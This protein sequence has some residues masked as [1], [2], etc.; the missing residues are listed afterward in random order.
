MADDVT[1][2]VHVR[3]LTGP[4]FRS[5]TH[6]INQLQR[7]ANGTLGTLRTLGGQLDGVASSAA[8]AGQS[9]GG[10]MG[11][12]GQ[13]IGAA[14]ALG[15]TLLPTIGALAPMLT[16]LAVVGG[17]A[18]LAM[19][20]LKK[21]AKQLKGPFEE[22]QKIANKA[23]APHTEKAVKSLK[24]AM[25]DLN[26][27]IKLGADTFGRITEKAARFADSPA[28]KGAL[29]KNAEM[30]AKWVEEFA[31][32]VGTFTQAFLDFGTKSQP[33][34]DAWDQLL[35]GTLDTGL[36]DM[37]KEMEVGIGGSSDVLSGLASLINDSLLPTLGQVAGRFADAFGPLL[38]EMLIGAGHAVELFGELF[39]GAM[40]L[41]EP[42]ADVAA[43]LFRGLNEIFKIGAS[44]AGDFTKAFGGA[45]LDTVAE[46][47]G[48]GGKV[49]SMRGGFTRFSDWVK[50][51]QATI[52][53]AFLAMGSA[54]VDMVNLGIQSVPLLIGAF[55]GMADMVLTV[56]DGMISGLAG[57]FGDVPIVGEFFKDANEQFDELAGGFRETL[58][59]MQE[60]SEE[61]A[62]IAGEKL[63]RI[64][65]KVGVD[66]AEASLE[67]I[68][69]QLK[70]PNLTAT[71]KAKLEVEK[72]EAEER[73]REA[74]ERL[75][76][77]DG[78]K[79]NANV[80]ANLSGFLGG[81]AVAN[82]IA[83]R[84]KSVKV[85]ANL[86]PFRSAV[87]GLAGQV[88]GTSYIN[89]AYRQ[90][91][92]AI[93]GGALSLMRANGGPVQRRADGGALQHFP[94]GG[95]VQGPGGPRTD[96]IFATFAS[97]A[98][99]AVSDTEF[100]VQSSAV[101]K[102]GLPMLEALNA[103]TLK[104]AR[105]AKGGVTKGEAAARKAAMSDLTISRFG[106]AAGYRRS[107]FGSALANASSISSLVD[108]LNQWRTII[109]KATHGS[110]E[111]RLLKQLDSTGKK[112]LNYERQLDKASSSLQK[113]RDRLNELKDAALQLR[114]SVKS[115]V[116][117]SANITR[118]QG[119]GPITVA[120]IM[121][122][123]TQSRDKADAFAKALAD[124]RKK[125]LSAA[126]IQQ[127]GE[128]GIEG[129]GL[130]TAG[131]LLGASSSEITSM[132]QLQSQ[133]TSAAVAAGKTTA[134]AVYAGQI[135]TQE[136]LVKAWEKTTKALQGSMDSLAKA[137]ERAVEKAFGKKAAGGIVGAAASGGIRSNLT[138][139][140]EQGPELLNLPP[141][142]RVWSNPDS[143]RMQRQAWAS[144]LNEPPRGTRAGMP[145]GG[146]QEVRVVLDVRTGDQNQWAQYL[147]ETLR[148]EVRARGG[149]QP[150]FQPPRSR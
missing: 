137:M 69:E 19:D 103:G 65:V 44:V 10:G 39:S 112:L 116:L 109:R 97:G 35:G 6:N 23:V 41:V 93:G 29:A 18:A 40:T 118:N 55:R 22:W 91:G 72:K 114:D 130:E 4:G 42:A 77:F 26:P 73:L 46:F 84:G 121:G 13:A 9:F 1:I 133:I 124:L 58:G 143:K 56:I 48:A 78:K 144:M 92:S 126:L 139:V 94:N 8:N 66:Q 67:Y 99:A 104:M 47:A 82:K 125:G 140:G 127:I 89:V 57:A 49:D 110:T 36:P 21:K 129:G 150:T 102:Y 64:Q 147:V 2:T 50:E 24:S 76:A 138:W 120:S 149:M 74:R 132:N 98:T 38:K 148:K 80:G 27:V 108:A 62:D 52:R 63:N 100:V 136:K 16:G 128:A 68:K 111:N 145:A 71:R 15:T 7:N 95:L 85:G 115:G 25:K 141:G 11:L 142:A 135:A 12:R 113:S 17:G 70:D 20:D 119:G 88:V 3:D 34:L 107:E 30:G 43:D 14:A 83:P 106:Q 101:K 54:M 45:L 33:A 117:S 60:K 28:F 51:N 81:I 86:G 37:F 31:G 87:G 105:L 61:F 90:V 79:A 122:G 146:V 59:G 75:A 53:L 123:L 5:V 131:A 134:D 96:S 32:S